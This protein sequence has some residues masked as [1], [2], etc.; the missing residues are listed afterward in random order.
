MPVEGKAVRM[1]SDE[2]NLN[3]LA[4]TVLSVVIWRI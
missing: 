4:S 1:V 2:L 3:K